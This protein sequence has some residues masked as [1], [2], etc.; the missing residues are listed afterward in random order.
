MVMENEEAVISLC[1]PGLSKHSYEAEIREQTLC[2]RKRIKKIQDNNN[3]A[4]NEAKGHILNNLNDTFLEG[5]FWDGGS[6]IM[7]Q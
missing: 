5:S 6:P 7:W 2:R 4:E 3:I 1:C